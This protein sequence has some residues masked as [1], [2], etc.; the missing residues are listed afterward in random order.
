M[1]S[2][3][4]SAAAR[5]SVLLTAC[6]VVVHRVCKASEACGLST[7]QQGAM[8]LNLV[9]RFLEN[10]EGKSSPEVMPTVKLFHIKRVAMVAVVTP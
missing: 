9:N 7:I 5:L 6:R 2:F 1:L 8:P 10:K 4:L 3:S